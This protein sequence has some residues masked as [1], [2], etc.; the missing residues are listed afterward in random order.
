MQRPYEKTLN[1]LI[2]YRKSLRLTQE[3]MAEKLGMTQT[4]YSKIECNAITITNENFCKMREIGI[5]TDYMVTGIKYEKTVL[6]DYFA[7]CPEKKRP[8]FIELIV[9]Y[10]NMFSRKNDKIFSHNEVAVLNFC[11]ERMEKTKPK[12]ME[13]ETIWKFLRRKYGYSQEKMTALMDINSKTYRSIEYGEIKPSALVLCNLY[14]EFGYYPSLVEDMKKNYLLLVN[15]M[16]IQ[17]PEK[18]KAKIEKAIIFT[19]DLIR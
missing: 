1:R 14:A 7:M 12:H 18:D 19:L 4:N 11:L 16:W 9:S 6:D 13:D 10:V 5:D 8:Y 17:L 3:Q 15:R 2:A